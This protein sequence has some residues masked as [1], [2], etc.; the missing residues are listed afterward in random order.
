MN[1]LQI[2]S[3]DT[4]GS[5]FNGLS[6]RDRLQTRGIE[7]RHLVWRRHSKDPL[8]ELAFN[9]PL[10]RHVAWGIDRV[11]RLLSVQSMLH[12]QWFGLP[13]SARFRAADI[14]H[15]HIIHDGYFSLAALPMLSRLRP[16]VWTFHDPWAMTGHCIHPLACTRWQTGCGGCPDLTLPF[17]LRRDRTRLNWRYKNVVYRHTDVDVVVAS[18]WMRDFAARSPLTQG[19]RFHQIPFGLD[20]Q[21]FSPGSKEAARERLGIFPGQTVMA[22]RAFEGP[23]KGMDY[24]KQALRRLQTDKPLCIL[25]T[26]E[27]GTFDEFIGKFQVVEL[28]WTNDDDLVIA[29]HQAADFYV[30]PSMAEAFGMMAAEAMA[31]GRPVLCFEGTSLPDV[32]FAPDAGL[33]VPRDSVALAAALDYWIANPDEVEKR[34]RRSRELAEAHYGVDLYVDRLAAVYRAAIERRQSKIAA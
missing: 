20:L 11:E 26:H 29:S 28:G 7:S 30:M 14:V 18:K 5:R 3:S 15:Y 13:L 21:R 25:T 24:L 22:L 9:L 33:A 27:K 31:C 32:T 16:T 6:I 4:L 12:L 19:F 8:V 1:L 2:N 34:G 10:S 17:P 23:F